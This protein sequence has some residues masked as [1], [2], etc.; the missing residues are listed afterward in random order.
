MPLMQGIRRPLEQGVQL[1][2]EGVGIINHKEN[3]MKI[4]AVVALAILGLA[5]TA[6]NAVRYQPN[7]LYRIYYTDA[8]K[9]SIAGE[10]I[11]GCPTYTGL[12]S[13]GWYLLEGE[14]TPWFV[15]QVGPKC[16]NGPAVPIPCGIDDACTPPEAPPP[17]PEE[18]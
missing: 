17:P 8:S 1:G 4:R 5:S 12:S 18:P 15:E 3:T 11:L 10:A 7:V 9:W 2:R 16:S 14:E 6:A 13:G